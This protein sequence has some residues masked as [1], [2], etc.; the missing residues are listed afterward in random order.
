MTGR[1]PDTAGMEEFDF[2]DSEYADDTALLYCSRCDVE[3]QSPAL[4]AHFGDWGMEVHAGKP[5]KDSKSEILFCPAPSSVYADAATRDDADLSEVQLPGGLSMPVV[6]VF[7]YLGDYVSSSGSD[8][9]AV[10]ARIA[11]AGKAFGALRKGLFGSSS[12]SAYA[13]RYAYEAL[14][15][16]ILLF[17]SEGW[18]L[19]EALLQRLRGFH[20]QCVRAM[21]RVTRTHTWRHH[22]S[23]EALR[24][25]LGLD[26]I[27]YYVSR[28]QLR[29]LGHV[30]RMDFGRLPRRMLSSWVPHKRPAG[31][32]RFTLGRTMAKAMDIFRLDHARWPELAADRGAWRAMLQS[33]EAPPG[34]RQAPAPAVPMPISHYSVRPRRAA[35]AATNRAI[36]ASLAVYNN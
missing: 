17:G 13:K 4:M 14:V 28:R 29:W 20:A 7:K 5:G 26:S 27:D 23:S 3:R 33:G 10:E 25:Q 18:C 9:S 2:D 11:D 35:A 1:R 31:A 16:S 6:S 34:F 32:P 24:K 36:R 19:T 30:A 21:S 22:I 15:L 8:E 12:I